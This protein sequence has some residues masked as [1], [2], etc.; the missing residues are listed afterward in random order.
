MKRRAALLL[1]GL[2]MAAC[3]HE[4]EPPDRQARVREAEAQ[5]SAQAF[6]TLRWESDSARLF[7]G[8]EVY[9]AKCRR[10]H[11]PLGRGE[12]EYARE[13]GLRIPSLVEAD[14]PYASSLDS[15]RHK[16]FVGH[17]AG[18]PIYGV[19]GIS[20]REIDSSAFYVLRGLRPDVMPEGSQ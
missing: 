18:M 6:D 7:A 5:Y 4:F 17:E 16:I 3:G 1:G 15:L 2:A 10:C 9:A 14:W 12:T 20:L 11:G 19:A 8:N 13:R